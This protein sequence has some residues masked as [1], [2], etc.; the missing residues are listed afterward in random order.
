MAYSIMRLL[1]VV[2]MIAC[3]VV[4]ASFAIFVVDQSTNASGQQQEEVAQ[5]GGQ[6]THASAAAG[7][8]PSGL[9]KGIDEVA[10]QITSP[11][12]GIVSS[13]SSEW[14]SQLVRLVL[15]LLVYGLGV[16]YIVRFISVRA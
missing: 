14:G 16:G 8:H 15:S 10:E 5:S 13:S 7:S 2:S 11:F 1:R 9:H 3:L 12:A 4:V 6:A